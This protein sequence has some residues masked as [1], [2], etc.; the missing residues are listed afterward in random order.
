M[1][2]AATTHIAPSPRHW[3]VVNWA[4]DLDMA[5]LPELR[6]RLRRA[7]GDASRDVVVDLSEV[8]FM[9]CSALGLLMSARARL[10]GRLWLRGIPPSVT[11]LLR[12]A[13]LRSAFPVFDEPMLHGLPAQMGNGGE[14]DLIR[15]ER[16]PARANRSAKAQTSARTK[17]VMTVP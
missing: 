3:T 6:T 7:I 15:T 14:V 10:G 2:I 17:T 1:T 12:V 4:G 5:A 13:C 9:D 8:T 11:W 16:Q